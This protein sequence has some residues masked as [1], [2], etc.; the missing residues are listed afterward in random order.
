[1]ASVSALIDDI[2]GTG[3]VIAAGVFNALRYVNKPIGEHKF[4]FFGAG[5]AATGVAD[6]IRVMLA[7]KWFQDRL[8]TDTF[9][10]ELLKDLFYFVDSKGL[11]STD[12]IEGEVLAAHKAPYARELG[13]GQ[14]K[15]PKAIIEA[16]KP[17]VLVGLAAC[18]RIW[19]EECIRSFGAM[20]EIPIIFALSNPRS[21]VRS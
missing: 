21:S 4:L 10:S 17:T 15:D 20:N 19:D 16:V 8:G 6:M 13:R 9:T 5:S 1:M 3:T 14:L 12:R 2:Q 18:G 7:N 11:I